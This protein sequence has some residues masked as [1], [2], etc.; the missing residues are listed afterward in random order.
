VGEKDRADVYVTPCRRSTQLGGG[1]ALGQAAPSQAPKDV[2]RVPRL[3]EEEGQQKIQNGGG[4][5]VGGKEE[6]S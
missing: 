3:K 4:K 6:Q 1:S 5:P 2:M